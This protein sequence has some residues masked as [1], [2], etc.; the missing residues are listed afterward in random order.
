MSKTNIKDRRDFMA[1]LLKGSAAGALGSMGQ[2]ALMNQAMAAAPSF[3]GYKALVCVFLTGGNDS[4][5]M[6]VP[7][8][9]SYSDYKAIRGALAVA[10]NDL[11]ISLIGADIHNGL[12][13]KGIANPYNVDLKHQSAYT[14]GYYDLS[15]KGI[16]LG[17]NA[18]MPEFA[19][20]VNDNKVTLIANVGN[21]VTPVTKDQI[22]N[23]SA[24]LPLFLFA[25]NQQQRAL[26]T[27][28]GNNLDDIGWAGKIADA[29]KGI[30]NNASL[31]L[32]ISYAG[33]NRMLIGN[34][35]SPVVLKPGSP[36]FFKE[37]RQN[38][39]HFEDDRRAVFK[40]LS[41]LASETS[42]STLAFNTTGFTDNNP[43]MRLYSNMINRSMS[44][45]DALL[46]AWNSQ[47]FEY[48]SKGSYGE[49]L[50][51]V[52]SANDLG[53]GQSIKG[54]FI[55]QLEAVAKMIDLGAKDVFNSGNYKRQIFFVS[56]GGFDTHF[57]QSNRHPLLL[58]EL[59][60]GLWKFQ[61]A[62]EELGH[63]EKVTTFS[64]SDFGRSISINAGAGTDHAWGGHHF[65]MG[66]A[67]DKRSGNLNGGNL[68]GSLPSLKQGSNDD[69]SNKGRLIPSLAQDQ[70]NASI[71]SWFGVDENLLST[72]FPNLSNFERT[73]GVVNSAFLDNLFV[74]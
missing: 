11:N 34:D 51:D 68:I 41:G 74:S 23:N 69:F 50:F 32:N 42:S 67:G 6:L 64:M 25:H 7:T 36:P 4:L 14:K 3:S 40:A 9:A 28:Q 20:L 37:M 49:K 33:N 39:N 61:K 35:T 5:N 30:N 53:F 58:R 21:L 57:S 48:S 19:Q 43:F 55:R 8:N 27:G 47:S 2:L 13:G 15:A 60:L 1:M 66:G 45:N 72:V 26:Q 17:V 65:V 63:E 62:M 52:V 22:E 73:S 46:K 24:N 44:S 12:L 56:M 18:V 71:C 70:L 16:K 38:Q 31:G 54:N 10:E 29:W 59:S